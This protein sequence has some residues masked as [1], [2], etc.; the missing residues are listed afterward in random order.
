MLASK[1]IVAQPKC[2]DIARHFLSTA[3]IEEVGSAPPKLQAETFFRFWTK[4]EAYGKARGEGLA[5]GLPPAEYG[6][7]WSFHEIRPAPGY[8]GTVAL[9]PV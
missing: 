9:R 6:N 5:D 7:R 4:R 3:E 1:Q 2:L 8:I